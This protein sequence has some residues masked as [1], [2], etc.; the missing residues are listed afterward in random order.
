M[1]TLLILHKTCSVVLKKNDIDCVSKMS[2]CL[3]LIIEIQETI[4]VGRNVRAVPPDRLGSDKENKNLRTKYHCKY[5]TPFC[6]LSIF[7]IFLFGKL[8]KQRE[9]KIKI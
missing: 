2:S 3:Q 1:C 7:M 9:N 6:L 4:R 5:D 8:S